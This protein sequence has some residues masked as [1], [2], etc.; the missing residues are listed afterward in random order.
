MKKILLILIFISFTQNLISQ[1]EGYNW[2]FG[3]FAG[4]TFYP[5]GSN[6]V[7]LLDGKLNSDEGSASISDKDGK[8]LFYTDGCT[9]WNKN[10]N[11]MPNGYGLYG[12]ITSAQ[13]A[14]I[15][16]KPNSNNI[17]FIFTIDYGLSDYGLN[18]SIVDINL[19]NGNG[20]IINKNIPLLTGVSEKLA[21]TK[22]ANGLDYWITCHGDYNSSFYT[23]LVNDTFNINSKPLITQ[24]GDD[25]SGGASTPGNLKFSPD[26]KRLVCPFYLATIYEIYDFDNKT[27]KLSNCRKLLSNKF[28]FAYG[29]EFSPDC[30]KLYTTS[31]YGPCYLFQFDLN[32]G[33]ANAILNSMI[34]LDTYPDMHYY[35]AL[36]LGPDGKI[37][38]ARWQSDYLGVI[39]DPNNKGIAC[40]YVDKGFYL[41]GKRSKVGLPSV[42]IKTTPSAPNPTITTTHLGQPCKGDSVL[43]EADAGYAS[44]DWYDANTNQ[45]LSSGSSKFVVHNSGSYYV[46]VKD[47]NGNVGV[48]ATVQVTIGSM[49]NQILILTAL[50][51]GY[52]V[53]DSTTF[54]VMKCKNVQ[55]TN[56]SNIPFTLNKVFFKN[57]NYFS[58]PGTQ[59]PIYFNPGETRFLIV[60]YT[61]TVLDEQ[62][63]TLIFN[64][65]CSEQIIPLKALGIK[66]GVTSTNLGEPCKGDSVVLEAD[67]GYASYEWYD[68]STNQMVYSGSRTFVVHTSGSYYVKVKDGKGNEATSD[69][70]PVSIGSAGNQ[71]QITSM[72]SSGYFTFDSTHFPLLNCRKIQLKNT[73]GLLFTLNEVYLEHNIC[74]SVPMSQFPIIFQPGETKDLVVCYSPTQLG[75]QTDSLYFDD[76]CGKQIIPLKA[77]SEPNINT[78]GGRC[79][80]D[81]TFKTK[82]LPL[83]SSYVIT[84]PIINEASG[85]I[86][87]PYIMMVNINYQ[88]TE[89]CYLYNSLGEK[90]VQGTRQISSQTLLDEGSLEEGQFNFRTINL[91][92]GIYFIVIHINDEIFSTPIILER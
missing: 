77:L 42:I 81:I 31:R 47:G 4:M 37:Y 64:D 11:V 41:G 84:D 82:K 91:P 23:Y 53:F 35:G 12:N 78:A 49:S 34:I 85:N 27:G 43:L 58:A 45:L 15:I 71:I 56:T 46:K 20:D 92:S 7:P 65:T 50:D 39:N 88:R 52:F 29:V 24:I 69:V 38:C 2:Y 63:D 44:Y 80:A 90:L 3:E 68:A 57:N 40:N 10:H 76:V 73:S 17:Y 86:A 9:V 72:L 66:P 6:P 79:N 51:N 28:N 13:S 89:Q 67:A 33:N 21:F 55:L 62:I 60:C 54:S 83:K 75:T 59:F 70:M 74:F 61:P 87:L 32:A 48:S 8:L 16:P 30:S 25:F 18:Y 19:D 36:Q 14:I 26:G 5:T 1:K 22:H